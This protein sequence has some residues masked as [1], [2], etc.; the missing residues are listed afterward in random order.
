MTTSLRE[1]LSDEQFLC[2]AAEG[3]TERA[4]T[5]KYVEPQGRRKRTAVSAAPPSFSAPST[6][7][8]RV[9]AGRASGCRWPEMPSKTVRG[10][11]STG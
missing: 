3:A 5:G 6:N 2:D 4:F 8:T 7:M 1:K 11:E 9:Q 10:H